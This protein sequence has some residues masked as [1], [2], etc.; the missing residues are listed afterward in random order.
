PKGAII[1]I[2]IIDNGQGISKEGLK[3]LWIQDYNHTGI[4]I[5]NVNQRL[6]LSFGIRYGLMLI[7]SKGR[8]TL[9]TLRIPL[10]YITE[11]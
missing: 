4:G 8:G 7:S 3:A 1:K 2:R 10:Q 9:A 11:R 5:R 6:K